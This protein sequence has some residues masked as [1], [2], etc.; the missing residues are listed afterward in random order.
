MDSNIPIMMA[1]WYPIEVLNYEMHDV[2][3]YPDGISRI[4]SLSLF[5]TVTV[6]GKLLKL[7]W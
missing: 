1:G 5:R 7:L 2:S 4:I 3:D 6:Y